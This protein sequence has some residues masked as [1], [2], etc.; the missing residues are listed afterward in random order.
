VVKIRLSD[1]TEVGNVAFSQ[2]ENN[3]GCAAIDTVHG[4]AYFGTDANPGLIIKLRLSDF[5]EV[6]VLALD[7]TPEATEEIFLRSAVIDTSNGF[8]YFGSDRSPGTIVKVRLSDFTRVGALKLNP[9]E[10]SLTAAVIDTANGFAYFSATPFPTGKIVKIRL[11]DFTR[12]GA[13]TLN[14][15]ER[16]SAAV[17]DPANGFAYFGTL[18]LPGSIVK[19]R[20]SDF[21]RV[22]AVT[23]TDS[24]LSAAIDTTNGFGYFG[25]TGGRVAKLRLSDFSLAGEVVTGAGQL[26]TGVIDPSRGFA[27]FGSF[28]GPAQVVQI[29]LST[30]TQADTLTLN[31]GEDSLYSAVVDTA[32]RAAYFGTA[33][34]PGKIVKVNLADAAPTPTP[35]PSPTPNPSP[36]PSP[37]PSPDPPV[38]LLEESGPVANLAAAVDS[39]LLVRDPFPVVNVDDLLNPGFDRNTRVIVFVSNLQLQAGETAAS[40]VV[41]LSDSNSQSFDLPAEDIRATPNTT[42][43][44]VVFRLP[45]NVAIGACTIR[46]KVHG[47]TSNPGT[48]RIRL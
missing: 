40:V 19:V 16:G 33:T 28:G 47:Q 11:S 46:I 29:N 24:L 20:L 45:S 21:S 35:T 14:D 3:L 10:D 42:F 41:N 36:S 43:T 9:G 13:L 37:A 4:F 25:G 39:V 32:N 18:A 26:H 15:G 23:G 34:I 8:A 5:T 12:V 7:D 44:Q 48:I 30:F 1:F 22:G 6:G 2:G 17:I 31:P 38:L 27:Y